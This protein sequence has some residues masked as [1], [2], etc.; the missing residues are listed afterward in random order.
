MA[1][2]NTV[3]LSTLTQQEL[4]AV[5]EI[6]SGHLTMSSKFECY[7]DQVEDPQIKQM[8]KQASKDAQT[9]ASNLINSL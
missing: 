7:S 9:T 3:N 5:R 1:L 4:Q 6:A 8:F 2:K